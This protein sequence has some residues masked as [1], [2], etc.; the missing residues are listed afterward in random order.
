MALGLAKR[1]I[2]NSLDNTWD[3]QSHREAEA[4]AE[5]V[6]SEDHHEG[7]RAFLEKRAPQFKGR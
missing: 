2:R 6:R 3:Q 7:L 1:L 4:I 5:A